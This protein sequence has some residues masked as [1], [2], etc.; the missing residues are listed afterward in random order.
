VRIAMTIENI[1][2]RLKK[3]FGDAILSETV[4]QNFEPFIRISPQ[5]VVDIMLF[6]RDEEDLKFDYL[7]C[8]SGMDYKETLGVV[9]HLYSIQHKHRVT[10]KIEVPK[11]DPKVPSISKVWRTVDWHEREAYDMFGLIFVGHE[12]LIRILTPYDWEGHPL[13]K[14]YKQPEEYHGLKVPY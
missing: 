8:L 6:L 4:E 10:I 12:N 13:R 11:E 14:D 2:E 3:E 9:Y 7:A 1:F 5:N